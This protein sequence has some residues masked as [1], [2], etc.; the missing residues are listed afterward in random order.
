MWHMDV[1]FVFVFVL[2]HDLAGVLNNGIFF[3]QLE[4][5]FH[6]SVDSIVI[7]SALI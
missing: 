4:G 6:G 7:E 3:K 1:F 2:S 5:G